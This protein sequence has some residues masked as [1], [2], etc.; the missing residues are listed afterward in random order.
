[1]IKDAKDQEKEDQGLVLDQEDL[2]PEVVAKKEE[3]VGKDIGKITLLKSP[4]V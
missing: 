2:D 3:I 4:L 1:V